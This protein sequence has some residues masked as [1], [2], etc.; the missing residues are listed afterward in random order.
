MS[1]PIEIKQLSFVGSS[2]EDLREFPEEVRQ[3]MGY[4]LFQ[5]QRGGKPMSAK[6]LKGFGGS[7][8]RGS[9]R[10]LKIYREILIGPFTR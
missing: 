9:W 6:P 1:G 2:R 10:S 8:V 7:G 4:A 5:V 3:D